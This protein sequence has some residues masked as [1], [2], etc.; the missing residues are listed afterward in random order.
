ML[1]SPL[2]EA[3]TCTARRCIY[4]VLGF[5]RGFAYENRNCSPCKLCGRHASHD[6][7]VRGDLPCPQ[8]EAAPGTRF[9]PCTRGWGFFHRCQM[10]IWGGSPEVSDP[11]ISLWLLQAHEETVETSSAKR[12]S[13]RVYKIFNRKVNNSQKQHTQPQAGQ[14]QQRKGEGGIT[15]KCP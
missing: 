14:L 6:G 13:E 1:P 8:P 9:L 12:Q 3:L 15:A 4:N 2:K 7:R 10:A 11:S 5:M